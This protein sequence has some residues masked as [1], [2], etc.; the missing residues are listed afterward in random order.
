MNVKDIAKSISNNLQSVQKH[1]QSDDKAG[2]AVELKAIVGGTNSLVQTSNAIKHINPPG[3]P[4]SFSVTLNDESLTS[5][6]T[7]ADATLGE[8]IEPKVYDELIDVSGYL[9]ESLKDIEQSSF[10]QDY[11]TPALSAEHWRL[12]QRKSHR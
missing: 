6:E 4:G 1:Y 9:V 11:N 10:W 3:L 5:L 8:F 12:H 2:A 7:I